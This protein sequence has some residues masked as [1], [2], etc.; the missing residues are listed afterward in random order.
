M[1]IP[2]GESF[3]ENE[4]IFS[5]IADGIYFARHRDIGLLGHRSE[6]VL[7]INQHSNQ[8]PSVFISIYWS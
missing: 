4:Y 2:I 1:I 6:V 7:L 5:H 8:K 3:R